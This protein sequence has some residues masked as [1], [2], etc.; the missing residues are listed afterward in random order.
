MGGDTLMIT[1]KTCAKCADDKPLSEFNKDNGTTDGHQSWCRECKTP[2]V[3]DTN[4]RRMYVRCPTTG[5]RIYAGL[6]PKGSYVTP[7]NIAGM[8][9][10][11][12]E[13]IDNL[14]QPVTGARQ[15]TDPRGFVYV[16]YFRSA[17]DGWVVTGR[18]AG[19]SR[20]RSYDTY[21]PYRDFV[22]IG[23]LA[24]N[25]RRAAEGW[26]QGLFE[27]EHTRSFEWFEMSHDMVRKL[28]SERWQECPGAVE[29]LEEPVT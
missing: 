21:S 23:R 13:F 9:L 7:S 4:A 17:W 12:S 18:A 10:A 5:K 14:P 24:T 15:T 6:A 3:A 29:Y 1:S 11:P 27:E 20:V 28:L 19:N 16:G 26:L 2:A 8:S 25:D 22:V